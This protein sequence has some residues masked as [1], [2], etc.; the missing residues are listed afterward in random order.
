MTRLLRPAFGAVLLAAATVVTWYAWLG[1]DTGYQIDANGNP[2]GPY[3]AAQVAACVLTLA[4]VLVIA[5]L[6]RVPPLVAAAAMTVAFTVAWTA[7]AAAT[8]VTGLFG[9]GAVLVF[10]GMAV[11]T[12]VVA[13][14]A[15]LVRRR[16]G[17]ADAIGRSA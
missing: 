1:R 9:V 8:D 5:V 17:S 3:T 2:T 16:P 7:Q 14:L 6:L 11:G 15:R 13:L 4:V 12:S 10:A